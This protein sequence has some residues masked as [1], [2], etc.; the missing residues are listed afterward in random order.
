[1]CGTPLDLTEEILVPDRG[2]LLVGARYLGGVGRQR[3]RE[4]G[5]DLTGKYSSA[6]VAGAGGTGKG[7]GVFIIFLCL[8]KQ[9]V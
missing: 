1:M 5:P 3:L 9:H 7:V 2:P 6:L 4:G 8:H